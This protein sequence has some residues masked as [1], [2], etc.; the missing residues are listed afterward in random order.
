MLSDG[1]PQDAYVWSHLKDG[2][3]PVIE[4]TGSLVCWIAGATTAP[5]GYLT[6]VWA[7][8]SS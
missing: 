6:A 3:A 4:G 2:P 5:T 1:D 8:F 7:E